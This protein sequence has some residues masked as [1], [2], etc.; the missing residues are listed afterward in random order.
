MLYL[1]ERRKAGFL[2]DDGWNPLGL[3]DRHD[4]V[5]TGF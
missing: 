5:L 4:L 2:A 3:V 1:V